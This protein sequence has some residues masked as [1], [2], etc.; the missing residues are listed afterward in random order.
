MISTMNNN[1]TAACGSTLDERV[2]ALEADGAM[3]QAL[4]ER[5]A[6]LE[7][8]LEAGKGKAAPKPK[9]KAKA[10]KVKVSLSPSDDMGR[11]SA[12]DINTELCQARVCDDVMPGYKPKV[13]KES[14][15]QKTKK[16]GELCTTCNKAFE[17]AE[18]YGDDYQAYK[19]G[20]GKWLGLIT[21]DPHP[22][23]H[24][25]GTAWAEKVSKV[26]EAAEDSASDSGSSEKMTKAAKA[27]AKAAAKEEKEA[28]KAEKAAAKAAEKAAKEAAKA[29]KATKSKVKAKAAEP[30]SEV[31]SEAESE[32]EETPAPKE[33]EKAKEKAVPKP[34]AEK[35]TKEKAVPKEKAAPKEKPKATK[36]KGKKADVM[37]AKAAEEE[38]KTAYEIICYDDELL[39]KKANGDCYETDEATQSVPTTYYGHMTEDGVVDKNIPEQTE[40]ESDSE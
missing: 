37:P 10:E 32:A 5:V 39:A 6:A 29:T 21:E 20:H 28:A 13:F 26:D 31:A 1:T 30:E 3:L 14:Q 11:L 4:H 9:A 7:A 18:E 2:A 35:A 12:D 36:A 23:A 33:K 24:M 40:A 27:E 19:Q 38:V 25:L 15:C 8:A 34:K 16:V 17:K 22:T